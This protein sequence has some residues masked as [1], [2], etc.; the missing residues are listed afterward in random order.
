MIWTVPVCDFCQ[1]LVKTLK[2]LV[3]SHVLVDFI[4][5]KH[6][7]LIKQMFSSIQVCVFCVLIRNKKGGALL[8]EDIRIPVSFVN[9]D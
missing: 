1:Q 8:P 2:E 5:G 3:F 9:R 6:G 7:T 4:V